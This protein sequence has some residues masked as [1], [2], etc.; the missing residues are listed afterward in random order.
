MDKGIKKKETKTKILNQRELMVISR[1]V[2]GRMGETGE[3]DKESTF[4]DD[5]GVCT[6]FLN[7]PSCSPETNI[8]LY[9]ILELKIILR[10]MPFIKYSK[11]IKY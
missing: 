4:H 10:N 6:E 5:H 9:I 11:F 2:R 1:E 8:T 7:L 3:G